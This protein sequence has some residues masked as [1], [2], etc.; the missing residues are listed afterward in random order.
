MQQNVCTTQDA[1]KLLGVSLRTVQ[2][3]VE[4]G[5]LRAWKTPGGHRRVLKESVDEVLKK[6]H[7]Q[8]T[9]GEIRATPAVSILIAEDNRPLCKLYEATI[10]SWKLPVELKVVHD[11]FAA[12]VAIGAG[13]PNI[14][15]TDIAMPGMDGIMMLHKLREDHICDGSEIIVVTGLDTVRLNEMGGIPEG[16]TVLFKP[17]PF[18]LLQARIREIAN[19]RL[20]G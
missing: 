4:N 11:G 19:L 13:Q 15:I 1:A 17:V 20:A 10:R 6:R 16:I 18:A 12:L 2:L 14:I 5:S 7:L 3:W 9:P 8:S